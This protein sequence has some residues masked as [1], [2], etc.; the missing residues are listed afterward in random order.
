M[1]KRP[2]KSFEVTVIDPKESALAAPHEIITVE[3]GGVGGDCEVTVEVVDDNGDPAKAVGVEIH[4]GAV[5]SPSPNP[6]DPELLVEQTGNRWNGS[7]HFDLPGGTIS[8][9]LPTATAIIWPGYED[10]MGE[11][12]WSLP[13]T[14]YFKIH[15]INS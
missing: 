6:T 9:D 5:A 12:I 3:P 15:K 4:E 7:V 10:E 13:K 2:D 14:A 11:I 8:N 1:T